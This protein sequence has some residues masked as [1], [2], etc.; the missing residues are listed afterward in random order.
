[1]NKLFKHLNH[2]IRNLTPLTKS[3]LNFLEENNTQEQLLMLIQ[4]YNESLIMC[5]D[6]VND[7]YSDISKK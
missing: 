6:I 3:E 7:S 1:M 4:S 5:N 2:K